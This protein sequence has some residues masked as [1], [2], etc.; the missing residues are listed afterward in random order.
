MSRGP[1]TGL[2]VLDCEGLA[3]A[4][5]R[6][7][8]STSGDRASRRRTHTCRHQHCDAR[9]S[10][11]PEDRPGSAAMDCVSPGGCCCLAGD[12]RSRIRPA[13]TGWQARPQA[14]PG[15]T[16]LRDRSQPTRAPDDLHIRPGRHPHARGVTGD[17]GPPTLTCPGPAPTPFAPPHPDRPPLAHCSPIGPRSGEERER[18]LRPSRIIFH[19]QSGPRRSFLRWCSPVYR[20]RNRYCS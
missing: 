12:R 4:A 18:E 10:R 5:R 13:R 8:L 20:H 11:P 7:A 16:G 19:H 3:R 15:C 2:V 17:S 9:R 14:R 1:A 6:D